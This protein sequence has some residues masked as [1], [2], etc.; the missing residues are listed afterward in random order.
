MS[1]VVT[2]QLFALYVRVAGEF[3]QVQSTVGVVLLALTLLYLLS[4]VLLLGAEINDVIAR[5]DGVVETVAPVQHRARE[6]RDRYL[7]RDEA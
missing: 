1:W 4:V 2:S 6:L 3:N 7:D 5:R